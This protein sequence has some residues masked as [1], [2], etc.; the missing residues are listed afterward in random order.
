[1]PFILW[2]AVGSPVVLSGLHRSDGEGR[3]A[4]EEGKPEL[5]TA[6]WSSDHGDGNSGKLPLQSVEDGV[7]REGRAAGR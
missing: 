2:E 5:T 3:L 1:M 7:L 6:P 4:S